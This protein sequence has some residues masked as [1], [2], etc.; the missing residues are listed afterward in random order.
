MAARGSLVLGVE[1]IGEFKKL[2][3][4]TMGSQKSLS[5]LEKSAGK[6]SSGI[7]KTLGAIGVGF[8]L[9]FLVNEFKEA[10]KAAV[11]DSKSVVLLTKA[12]QD[13]LGATK[14]QVDEVERF[15]NKTQLATSITDDKLRPAFAK[16]AIGTKDTSEAMKLLTVATDVAAGTGKNLDA[17]VQA[18]SRALAGN[19]TA[20]FRLVPS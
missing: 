7:N 1:I 10:S 2:A 4:A 13:N 14:S 8:S 5:S 17:V 20:L 12:L 18:M 11:E 9:G 15:I 19:E 16:L 6:I 3:D